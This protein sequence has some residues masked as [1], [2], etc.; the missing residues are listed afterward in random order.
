[1]GPGFSLSH[2]L[3]LSLMV[4]GDQTQAYIPIP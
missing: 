1:L 3:S 4:L 2:S